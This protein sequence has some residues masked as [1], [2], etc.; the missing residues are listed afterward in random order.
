M[1]SEV[2]MFLRNICPEIKLLHGVRNII[3]PYEL[4]L[5]LPDYKIA[6]ECNPTVTHNS[7]IPFLDS[8]APISPGYHKMKSDMCREKGIFL[9]HIF[10]Y[11]WTHKKISSYL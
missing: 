6:I 5:Y 4:D 7:S 3:S 11:E 10:G 1:E 2:S 8:D 9:F